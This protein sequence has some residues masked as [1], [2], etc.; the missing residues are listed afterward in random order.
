MRVEVL[1]LGPNVE[2]FDGQRDKT[3]AYT[4]HTLSTKGTVVQFN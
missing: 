4:A 3:H 1:A 2:G